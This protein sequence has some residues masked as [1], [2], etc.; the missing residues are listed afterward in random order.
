MQDLLRVRFRISADKFWEVPRE[1]DSRC[2]HLIHETN[3]KRF[4]SEEDS[5]DRSRAFAWLI[6]MGAR[7]SCHGHAAGQAQPGW[8]EALLSALDGSF[9]DQAGTNE[10]SGFR[11]CAFGH[12]WKVRR[13]S[14]WSVAPWLCAERELTRQLR[15]ATRGE[16]CGGSSGALPLDFPYLYALARKFRI[17][18]VA[19]ADSYGTLAQMAGQPFGGVMNAPPP[20]QGSWAGGASFLSVWG[21]SL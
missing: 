21:V 1:C 8:S 14:V 6:G 9:H 2:V 12:V 11:H 17:S 18:I 10:R 20:L 15:R 16:L 13:F 7:S 3:K 19:S 5:P 4:R